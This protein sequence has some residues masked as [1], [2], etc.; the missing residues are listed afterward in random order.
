M[1]MFNDRLAAIRRL[2]PTN[3]D[4][5]WLADELLVARGENAQL[6]AVIDQ[7]HHVA[8]FDE[9]GWGLEHS[10]DCRIAQTMTTCK[11]NRAMERFGATIGDPTE[12]IERGPRWV[13]LDV[14]DEGLPV[15]EAA[16]DSASTSE[17]Q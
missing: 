11:F 16:A 13:V 6:R 8:V 10:L 5:N 12:F 3:P 14:D 9:H 17:R 7:S 1:S 4:V 2:Y 15:M